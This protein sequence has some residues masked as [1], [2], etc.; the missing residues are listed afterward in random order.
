MSDFRSDPNISRDD[1]QQYDSR[2]QWG[3]VAV[4]LLLLGGLI[5]ASNWTGDIQTASNTRAPIET[6]GQGTGSAPTTPSPLR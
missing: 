3:A 1:M 6:T 5:V 4:I 2:M